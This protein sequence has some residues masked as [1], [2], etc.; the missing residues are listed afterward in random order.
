[1]I[2][3]K[4][5][6]IKMNDVEKRHW[7]YR[8]LH[9][10]VKVNIKNNFNSKQISILDAGCG[11]GGLLDCLQNDNYNKLSGFDLSIDAVN[12]SLNKGLNVKE[13]DLR[14]YEY[15]GKKYDVIISNDTMY[16]FSLEEQRIILNNFYNSLNKEGIV[17][18]NLPS[19]KAFGGV[20]DK[21]VGIKNRFNKKMIKDM[22]NLAQFEVFQKIY[23]P[24]LLSPIIFLFRLLQGV[25]L[26]H[27]KKI[28]IK[29]DIN[30]PSSLVN[31]ILYKV[32]K[33]ENKYIKRRPF[34]S[35]LFLVLKKIR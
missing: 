33:L 27:G 24:F 26:S 12:F 10:L 14:G 3:N 11:T 32:V 9:E 20:H 23:W 17:I 30:M 19:F 22:V 1:M 6:Y 34:G 16:F 4:N 15:Q 21:A 8:S 31:E 25:K 5:E 7:W 29:S 35:S 2:D 18:L 13:L 28:K